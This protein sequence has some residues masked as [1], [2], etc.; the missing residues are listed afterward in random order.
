MTMRTLC[1]FL[2][3]VSACSCSKRSLQ[4]EILWN[5]EPI[6]E[7]GRYRVAEAGMDIIAVEQPKGILSYCA[8]TFDGTLLLQSVERASIYQKWYLYWD[9]QTA[10]LWFWSSD[11]GLSVWQK[12]DHD[13]FVIAAPTELQWTQMP[14][15]LFR[16]LPNPIKAEKSHL[17][18]N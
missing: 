4:N 17:R 13:G 18:G 16:R 5:H 2:L 10:S 8:R 14:D 1:I 3:A 15:I 6:T 11:I 7:C 12:A 9:A